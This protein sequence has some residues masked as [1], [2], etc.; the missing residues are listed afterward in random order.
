MTDYS[1]I[2]GV[3]VEASPT[4]PKSML[5]S[6]TIWSVVAAGIVQVLA[7]W[8]PWLAGD[9]QTTDQIADTLSWIFAMVAAW[10][11]RK[12]IENS[13]VPVTTAAPR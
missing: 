3:K 7:K 12:A 4:P 10:K 6:A 11:A 1:A 13:R 2:P 8:F 9:P 5:K